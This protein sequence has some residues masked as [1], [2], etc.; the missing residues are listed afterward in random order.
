LG[1]SNSY[2]SNSLSIAKAST[3]G[4]VIC[5]RETSNSFPT[6]KALAVSGTVITTG[7]SLELTPTA[8]SQAANITYVAQDKVL[9]Q[10]H[11]TGTVFCRV[12]TVSGTTLT[13]GTAYTIAVSS[14][15]GAAISQI[16]DNSILLVAYNGGTA[17]YQP[18]VLTVTGTTIAETAGPNYAP[19][20]SQPPYFIAKQSGGRFLAVRGSGSTITCGVLL[21]SGTSITFEGEGRCVLSFTP[22]DRFWGV[23]SS[24]GRGF[25]CINRLLNAPYTNFIMSNIDWSGVPV[26]IRDSGGQYTGSSSQLARFD[27]NGTNKLFVYKT[28]SGTLACRVLQERLV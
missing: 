24:T 3:T 21:V 23:A 5:Y 8:I 17:Q 27:G 2:A 10:T 25:S 22:T 1:I 6:V 4:A 12:Y 20:F 13:A 9:V 14:T 15:A 7:S 18:Y 19:S 28:A 11:Y 16:V 26:S